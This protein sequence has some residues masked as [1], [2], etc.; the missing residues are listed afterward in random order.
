MGLVNKKHIYFDV[1]ARTD[2]SIML[3]SL[4]DATVNA[5]VKSMNN[6]AVKSEVAKE[7]V[8]SLNNIRI[9]EN[10]LY[11]T[12]IGAKD[13]KG[14]MSQFE[15][16]Y[17]PGLEFGI[18]KSTSPSY[19]LTY[20]AELLQK[21]IITNKV[22]MSIVM[23]NYI[24]IIDNSI[25]SM[26]EECVK[27]ALASPVKELK[28]TDILGC[29]ILVNSLYLQTLELDDQ[30]KVREHAR[31]LF[32]VL[33]ETIYF[34]SLSKNVLQLVGEESQVACLIDAIGNT[35]IVDLTDEVYQELSDQQFYAAYITR[36]PKE[37]I[38]YIRK[39]YKKITANDE[40]KLN[41]VNDE[42]IL[43]SEEVVLELD[44]SKPSMTRKEYVYSGK[45][46]RTDFI[47]RNKRQA[48]LGKAAEKLVYEL[49]RKKISDIDPSQVDKVVW[50]SEKYGDGKGYDIES[51]EID[52][53]GVVKKKYIEVKATCM[54]KDTPIDISR[55]EV[56]C[57]RIYTDEYIVYRL[58]NFKSDATIYKYY[59]IEGDL[60]KYKLDPTSYKLYT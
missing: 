41:N 12:V 16:Q 4:A 37:L 17:T 18:W 55:N 14:T 30:K 34:K 23:F 53:L 36:V 15:S 1:L 54:D 35:K 50:V 13:Y 2:K 10:G 28:V 43:E 6:V 8:N 31:L 39:F 7:L 19:K 60:T 32:N 11:G 22:Y 47:E 49:E 24:Q 3:K 38:G 33:S 42:L 51:I 57:S 40:E 21:S 59:T 46:R 44:S 52:S 45:A 5:R 9:K 29:N 56:E 25:V 20:L 26:L 48:K 27:L 58:Y